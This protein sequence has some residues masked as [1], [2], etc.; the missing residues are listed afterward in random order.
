M[1]HSLT[2]RAALFG[3]A[4][5]RTFPEEIALAL[6]AV[7]GN[8]VSDKGNNRVNPTRPA[9]DLRHAAK[10]PKR[11]RA[12]QCK[13]PLNRLCIHLALQIRKKFGLALRLVKDRPC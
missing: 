7:A 10:Q 8:S 6:S 9:S 1:H 13:Q 5:S 2:V 12:G 3:M 4:P 11:L